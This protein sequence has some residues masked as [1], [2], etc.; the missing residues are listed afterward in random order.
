MAMLA[1]S[2]P[3]LV[4][5]GNNVWNFKCVICGDSAKRESKTRGYMLQQGQAFFSYCHN[6]HTT[7][8][9]AKFLERVNPGIYD[10]YVVERFQ[11]TGRKAYHEPTIVLP[12]IEENLSRLLKL[13]R[14]AYLELDHPARS[15]LTKRL[16][17]DIWL[18]SLYYT[19]NFNRFADDFIPDKYD[20]RHNEPR[21]V[22]PM[23]SKSKKLL[24]F[25]GRS[26]GG[27]GKLRYI[28]TMLSPSNP[29]MFGLDRVD[30]NQTNYIFEGPLDSLFVDN[31][32]STCG[33]AI[34][35]EIRKHQLPLDRSVVVYDNEPRNPDIVALMRRAANKGL[36]VVIWPSK[37]EPYGNDINNMIIGLME[38][39]IWTFEESKLYV[40]QVIDKNTYSGMDATLK[41]N[42]WKR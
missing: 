11:E 42:E 34:H 2:L 6:C 1:G 19:E 40:K 35:K 20:T 8:P 36:N 37:I 32:V 13:P 41:I 17:P 4:D 10:Q 27:A 9:F 15:Y 28:T 25:Q 3:G 12:L 30:F 16:V 29:R 31:S 38:T 18:T 23:I 22:I 24:G 39:G 21:I 5:K 26:I 14:I 7:L 33:G